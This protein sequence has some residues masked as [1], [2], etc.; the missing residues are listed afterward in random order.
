MGS[1]TLKG[2]QNGFRQSKIAYNFQKT[3][4]NSLEIIVNP[5]TKKKIMVSNRRETFTHKGFLPEPLWTVW[6]SP[7]ASGWASGW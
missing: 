3:S 1:C 2:V 4:A 5:L 7:V 6:F